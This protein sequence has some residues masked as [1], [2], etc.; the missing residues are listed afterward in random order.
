MIKFEPHNFRVKEIDGVPVSKWK[1][2]KS[3]LLVAP[4][5]DV[6]SID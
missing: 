4:T 1:K 3:G 5:G 2:E 6:W